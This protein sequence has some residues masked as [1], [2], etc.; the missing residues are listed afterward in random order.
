MNKKD[1]VFLFEYNTWANAKILNAA[2]KVTNEQFLEN[3]NLSYGG[4][5]GTLH[6]AYTAEYL[7]RMRLHERISPSSIPPE[8]DFPDLASLR[9]AWAEEEKKMR[10]FIHGL[11]D[12]NLQ[13]VIPYTTMKGKQWEDP[14]WQALTH[15]ANHGTQHRAEA[16]ILLTDYGASPGDV[17][18]LIFYRE[19]KK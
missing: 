12:E 16:A 13:E 19:K 18:M 15:L 8:T 2:A 6:H 9:A 10:D 14:L 11:T 17:D 3:K 1:I 7:W 4:L 5:R